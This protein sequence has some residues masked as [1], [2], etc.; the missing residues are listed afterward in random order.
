M[1]GMLLSGGEHGFQFTIQGY[2]IIN[3]AIFAFGIF[4]VLRKSI[5]G[6]VTARRDK[7]V[8]DIEEARRLRI[9]AETKLADYE[10]RLAALETEAQAIL[11][12]ARAAGARER[13]RI[14]AEAVAAAER[15]RLDAEQRLEQE[16]RKLEA[17]LQQHAVA[18]TMQVARRLSAERIT[19]NHRRNLFNDYV[20]NLE[21]R[22]GIQ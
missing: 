17:E 4:W 20:Q 2:H 22:G 14:I 15:I 16:G 3:F 1:I 11:A 21:N 9:E 5:P 6:F 8:K 7:L 10:K 18:L 12:E 13:D 19:D